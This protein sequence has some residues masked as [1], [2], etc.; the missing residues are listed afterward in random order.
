MDAN[1]HH[2]CCICTQSTQ[3]FQYMGTEAPEQH[4]VSFPKSKDWLVLTLFMHVPATLSSA[5]QSKDDT[6]FNLQVIL[7]TLC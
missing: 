1:R 5:L 3:V 7:K 2:Y 6:I 4:P